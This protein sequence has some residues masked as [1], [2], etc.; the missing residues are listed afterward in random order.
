M[1]T[2]MKPLLALVIAAPVIMSAQASFA[3]TAANT[4]IVN[5]AV[6]T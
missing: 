3:N 1:N 4:A 6:L 2:F 5:K